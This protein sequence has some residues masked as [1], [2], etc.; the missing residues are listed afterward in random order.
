MTE[1]YDFSNV[2]SFKMLSLDSI[3]EAYA[4]IYPRPSGKNFSFALLATTCRYCSKTFATGPSKF[5]NVVCQMENQIEPRKNQGDHILQVR[6]RQKNRTQPE[7]AWRDTEVYPQVKFVGITFD[8]Q[9]TFQ[10]LFEDILDRCNNRYDRLK[11]LVNQK[12]GPSP[13]TIIQMYKQ[14]VRPIFEY[15]SLSTG[16]TSANIISKIQWL[17]NKFIRLALRL[18]KYICPRQLYDSSG[19]PYVKDRLL[20]FAAKSLQRIA[21]N[22]LVEE[23]ISSNMGPFPN[24][25]ISG[26]SCNI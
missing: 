13:S 25:L 17:Q 8:S 3:A 22:P 11:L 9:L 7:T 12:W 20:S 26:P 18:P 2:K 23:S 24:T 6:S 21:Q 4:L 19:L 5:G 16:T 14:C 10:K 15:G 1:L